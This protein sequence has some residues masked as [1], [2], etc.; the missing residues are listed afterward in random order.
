MRTLPAT[1]N[2]GKGSLKVVMK[3]SV[4]VFRRRRKR[5]EADS[6]ATCLPAAPQSPGPRTIPSFLPAPYEQFIS[7]FIRPVLDILVR[8]FCICFAFTAF[9]HMLGIHFCT[10]THK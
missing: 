7:T 4:S 9:T 3:L 10:H 5:E 1:E 8:A 2:G 6:P